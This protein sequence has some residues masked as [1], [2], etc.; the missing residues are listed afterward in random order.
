M[1]NATLY[2]TAG[3]ILKIA[4]IDIRPNLLR[5]YSYVTNRRGLEQYG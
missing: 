1:H 5:F 4:K 3:K 2:G